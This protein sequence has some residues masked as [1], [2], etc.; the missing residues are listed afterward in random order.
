VNVNTVF[1]TEETFMSKNLVAVAKGIVF[2]VALAILGMNSEEAFGQ[3]FRKAPPVTTLVQP[4]ILPPQPKTLP[5]NQLSPL[6]NNGSLYTIV[7]PVNGQ[8]NQLNVAYIAVAPQDCRLY[9]NGATLMPELRLMAS[10]CLD[11]RIVPVV[12]QATGG[13]VP[14]LPNGGLTDVN[15]GMGGAGGANVGN[16]IGKPPFGGWPN[17]MPYY[18]YNPYNYAGAYNPMMAYPGA[19]MM[20]Y[21]PPAPAP[22]MNNF[23]GFNPPANFF[24]NNAPGNDANGFGA[25]GNFAGGQNPFN[26]FKKPDGKKDDDADKKDAKDDDKDK[27]DAKDEKKQQVKKDN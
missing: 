15:G 10:Q 16:N 13:F 12:V 20:G 24:A 2:V 5:G 4:A 21:A 9:H 6:L 18:G 23:S 3:A 17:A 7:N 22:N 14:T 25:F 1:Q 19:N 11:S 8:P 26:A 27:K